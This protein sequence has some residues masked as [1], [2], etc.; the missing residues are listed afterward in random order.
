MYEETKV[1]F[2]WKGFIIKMIILILVIILIIKL[3]PLTTKKSNQ[4]FSENLTELKQT[5]KD[6]F[7][8]DN[9]PTENGDSKIVS[10]EQLESTGKITTLKDASGNKCNISKSYIK[11]T[12]NSNG[13]NLEVHLVCGSKK[14]TTYEYLGCFDSCSTTTTT[15]TTKASTNGSSSSSK[16]GSYSS[17]KSGSSTSSTYKS[18]SSSTSYSKSTSSTVTTTKVKKYAVI[19]NANGGSKTK[20]EYIIK[21]NYATRPND[22]TRTNYV[23]LGWYYNG[24]LYKFNIPVTKNIFLDAKWGYN[25]SSK[26]TTTTTKTTTKNVSTTYYEVSFDSNGGSSVSTQKV[27]KGYTASK[28]SNPSKS[29]ATFLGWYYNGELYNFGTRVYNDITLVAKYQETRTYVNTVYSA[30]YGDSP[31][32]SFTVTHTLAV[33]GILANNGRF[34]NVRIKSLRYANALTT[35]DQLDYYGSYENR[36]NYQYTSTPGGLGTITPNNLAYIGS[37]SVNKTNSDIYDRSVTWTGYVSRECSTKINGNTCVYGI[38]Y[39]V[40]WAYDMIN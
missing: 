1:R 37:A 26:T 13:Y 7:N 2:D 35:Q 23:F 11:A 9:L 24:E 18:G 25:S 4:V 16:S 28:P 40:T 31:R 5:G 6:F 34:S 22:P 12:K 20:T 10:L 36:L 14:D 3:L 27:A 21:D 32:S 19:F 17:S 33:P 15:T 38:I 39:D 8:K 30:G 29:N